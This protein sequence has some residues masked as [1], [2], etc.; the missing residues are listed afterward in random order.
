MG[1]NVVFRHQRRAQL[2]MERHG[3]PAGQRDG[4]A[5]AG[6]GTPRAYGIAA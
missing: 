3:P 4:G 1:S 2:Q 5:V 6:G